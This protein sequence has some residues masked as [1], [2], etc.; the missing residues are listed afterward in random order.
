[1]HLIIQIYNIYTGSVHAHGI[2]LAHNTQYCNN[3][4]QTNS[5]DLV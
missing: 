3:I 2:L 5:T 1:M 4:K